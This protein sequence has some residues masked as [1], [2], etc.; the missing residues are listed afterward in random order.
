MFAERVRLAVAETPLDLNEERITV[1]IGAAEWHDN[2]ASA[3]KLIS[4][5]DRALLEAKAAG[6]NRILVSRPVEQ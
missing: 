6:R 4:R 5:A 1:S 2:D 3:S